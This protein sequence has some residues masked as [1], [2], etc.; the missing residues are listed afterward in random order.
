MCPQV[1]KIKGKRI[2]I[3]CEC[4]RLLDWRFFG[5]P[6]LTVCESIRMS[7]VEKKGK[8][9]KEEDRRREERER[10]SLDTFIRS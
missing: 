10:K 1:K 7:V 8:R 4:V 5:S 9:E 2:G 6:L 3:T